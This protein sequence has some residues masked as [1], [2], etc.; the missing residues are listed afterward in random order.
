M[1]AR[2]SQ[3]IAQPA[4]PSPVHMGEKREQRI[5]HR[6]EDPEFG[7]EEE[8]ERGVLKRGRHGERQ[9]EH[10]ARDRIASPAPRQQRR[11]VHLLRLEP[12]VLA[13]DAGAVMPPPAHEERALAC[14]HGQRAVILL[15]GLG[16]F[17]IH[18]QVVLQ[19]DIVF[20]RLDR[21]R[22]V[23]SHLAVLEQLAAVAPQYVHPH[24]DVLG[25][26]RRRPIR[27]ENS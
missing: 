3:V 18:L 25:G 4:L 13:E 21:L 10:G 15:E 19:R 9:H 24:R 26:L 16:A 2:I 20:R 12:G 6:I 27:K 1:S 14:A 8:T 17:G 11:E 23:E 5:E 22:R 7:V